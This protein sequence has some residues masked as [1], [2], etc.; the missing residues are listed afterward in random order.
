MYAWY[1]DNTLV[2]ALD[3][4]M[5]MLQWPPARLLPYQVRIRARHRKLVRFFREAVFHNG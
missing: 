5:R 2:P 1:L 4:E 3:Y